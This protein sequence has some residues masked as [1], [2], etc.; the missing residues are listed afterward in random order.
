MFAVVEFNIGR[1]LIFGRGREEMSAWR[2][3]TRRR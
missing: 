3:S 1:S 2:R